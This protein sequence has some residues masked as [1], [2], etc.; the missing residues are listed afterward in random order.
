MD[1][2]ELR[3]AFAATDELPRK[4]RDLHNRAVVATRSAVKAG[5]IKGVEGA[6]I[7]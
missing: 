5:S 6:Q 4:L 1:K 2:G 3:L 7:Q